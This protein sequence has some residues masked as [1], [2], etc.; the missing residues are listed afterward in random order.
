MITCPQQITEVLANTFQSNPSDSNF[1]QTFLNYKNRSE[2][3]KLSIENDNSHINEPFSRL[4][5]DHAI[6]TLKEKKCP[7]PD[8]I[9]PEFRKQLSNTTIEHLFKILNQIWTTGTYPSKWQEVN[10]FPISKSTQNKTN[11]DSYRPISASNILSQI[12]QI[13]INNRLIW[14]LENKK[15]FNDTQ[16]GFRRGRSTVD[17]IISLNADIQ[18][19]IKNKQ[20]LV[21]VFFDI[22]KAFDMTWRYHILKS[23]KEA[24]V[25]GHMLT[26][27]H[28]FLQDRRFRIIANEYCSEKK[29]QANGVP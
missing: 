25:H 23:L 29:I 24:G 4:E 18:K 3:S 9:P 5:L 19:A 14:Y 7:G 28:N 12:P 17:H 6:K 26:Y 15:F 16:S 13:M 27:V 10:T 1:T 22:K 2:Q 20:N 11:P 21:A 8:G